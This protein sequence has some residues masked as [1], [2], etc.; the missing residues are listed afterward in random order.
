MKIGIFCGKIEIK[1]CCMK[2]CLHLVFICCKQSTKWFLSVT[3]FGGNSKMTKKSIV[4]VQVMGMLFAAWLLVLSN[5]ASTD[6]GVGDVCKV[7]SECVTKNC[8]ADNKTCGC[9]K[10]LDYEMDEEIDQINVRGT[11][12]SR[13]N[14]MCTLKEDGLTKLECIPGAS[15]TKFDGGKGSPEIFGKCTCLPHF[16]VNSDSTFCYPWGASKQTRKLR[17]SSQLE[18]ITKEMRKFTKTLNKY[19]GKSVKTIDFNRKNQT[20]SNVLKIKFMFN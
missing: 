8:L 1:T 16:S 3:G 6:K 20:D 14:Q 13:I 4:L 18:E 5:A 7:N 12:F 9:L 17:I 2:F 15:C 19:I 11:C 10:L